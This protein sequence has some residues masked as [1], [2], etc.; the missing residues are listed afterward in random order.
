MQS[1]D[2]GKEGI[3]CQLII[4]AALIDA[5]PTIDGPI[6][7]AAQVTGFVID[8]NGDGTPDPTIAYPN[9]MQSI[10][11]RGNRAYVPNIAASPSPPLRFN[12]D[13]QA[14]VN[15]IDN[16]SSGVAADAGMLNLHLGAL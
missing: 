11:I 16:A 4:P 15:I 2:T 1:D 13:T 14:F 7:L 8:S 5:L 12:V 10:V 3:V 6:T 9:Q